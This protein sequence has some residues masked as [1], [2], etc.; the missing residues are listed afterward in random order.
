MAERRSLYDMIFGNNPKAV[1]NQTQLKMLNGYQ[2]QFSMFGTEAYNSDVV[3]S[4]VDSIARHAAKLK[5]KH[6]RRVDGQVIPSSSALER[7]L[8]Q[9]PNP[10]MDAYSFYYKVVTL[11]YL[12]NNA[13]VYINKD[14]AG[15]VLGF[16]PIDATSVEMVEASGQIFAKFRFLGGQ[17]VTLPYEELIHLRRFFYKNDIFGE[18]S[19][20]ALLPTLELIQTTNDGIAN[21]VKSSAYLRGLLKFTNTMIK[22]EEIKKQRDLFVSDYMN[23]TNNGGIAAIDAKAEYQELKNNP[24]MIDSSQ[25]NAIEEKVYK[26]YNVNKDIIM[27]SYNEDTWNAFYESV[28]EPI[29]IQLSLEFTSKLFTDR[30]RGF[31]NEIVFEA[32]RLQYASNKTKIE[33]VK[34]LTSL[35][36]LSLNEAR[37][38]FNLSAIENG[39]KRIVSLNYVDASV[40]NQYQLGNGGGTSGN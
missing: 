31:G 10:F 3:R 23:I 34:E 19:E 15:N 32:N 9:R 8:Q 14:S 22:P 20:K 17:Q 5:P 29:A 24:M 37:E 25:M 13:F 16:Y 33:L 2:P 40:A 26:F 6:V 4:A 38:V 27:S 28:I 7:L 35:G 11:L 1:N 36:L 12:R 39:D 21:A 30:E 18:T